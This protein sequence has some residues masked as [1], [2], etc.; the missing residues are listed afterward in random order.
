MKKFLHLSVLTVVM[1][2]FAGITNSQTLLSHWPLQSNANDI[3]GGKNGTVVG[4]VQFLN[5]PFRGDVAYFDGTNGIIELPNNIFGDTTAIKSLA[6]ASIACWFN[7][8]GGGNWQRV[9][10]LGGAKGNW[11]MLYFCPRD[12]WDPAGFHVTAHNGFID[13]WSDFCY[14]WNSFTGFDTVKTN[15]WYHSVVVIGTGGMQIYIDGVKIVNADSVDISPAAIQVADSSYNVL[16]ASHWADPTYM[17]MISD[18]RIYGEALTDAQVT[19]LFATGINEKTI[20]PSINF[21]SVNGRILNTNRN[22]INIS[23]ISVY[24]ITGNLLFSSS[25]ISELESQQFT[26]GIYLVTVESNRELYTSKVVVLK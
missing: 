22:D 15:T 4:G 11:N 26:Q 18:F 2:F 5:D 10:S 9:Y 23:K 1:L 21:Y 12:G 19:A 8:E 25:R 13:K 6:N 16:G 20:S 3:V 14:S 7:W 24:N 17:G